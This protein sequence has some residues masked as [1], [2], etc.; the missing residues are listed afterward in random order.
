MVASGNTTFS[1]CPHISKALF[2]I[3]LILDETINL[4]SSSPSSKI[5]PLKSPQKLKQLAPYSVILSGIYICFKVLQ[6]LNISSE[7]LSALYYSLIS[8]RSDAANILLPYNFGFVASVTQ[9]TFFK[10]LHPS[11]KLSPKVVIV[12]SLIKTSTKLIQS[13]NI[14]VYKVLLVP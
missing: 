13:L 11:N 5:E 2:P 6:S 4:S 10:L 9:A 7:I 1:N 14:F 8:S 12:L 3:F